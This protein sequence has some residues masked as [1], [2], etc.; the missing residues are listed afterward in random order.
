MWCLS[1]GAGLVLWKAATSVMRKTSCL[2]IVCK[3]GDKKGESI[4]QLSLPIAQHSSKGEP[5]CSM[6][7]TEGITITNL[8]LYINNFVIIT[9]YFK[10]DELLTSKAI[11]V[12]INLLMNHSLEGISTPSASFSLDLLSTTGPRTL[13]HSWTEQL[14]QFLCWRHQ[15]GLPLHYQP[16]ITA[17]CL[18]FHTIIIFTINSYAGS[19][20]YF[21][22]EQVIEEVQAHGELTVASSV[23][24]MILMYLM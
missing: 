16:L 3:N 21:K 2:K 14:L 12:Y 13:C 9:C 10:E 7:H 5:I 20:M 11:D 22:R 17:V 18:F 6:G 23:A 15:Q 24:S 19:S 1:L 8:L 4:R